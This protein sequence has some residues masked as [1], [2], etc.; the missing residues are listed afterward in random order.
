MDWEKAGQGWGARA[1]EW[2]YLA[3]PYAL[4][5]YE[6]VFDQLGV[7]TGIRLLDIACGSG[8]AAWMAA[9]RGA[10]VSGVDASAQLIRI[11][12]ARTPSGIFQTGD[13]FALPFPDQSFDV[14]TSFNGVWKGCEGALEE[15]R[16]VLIPEGRLASLSGATRTEWTPALLAQGPGVVSRQPCRSQHGRG[17]HAKCHRGHAEVHGIWRRGAGDGGRS[18][19]VARRGYRGARHGCRRTVCACDRGCRIRRVLPVP[20][21]SDRP[22]ACGWGRRADHIRVRLGD[23]SSFVARSALGLSN[24][25]GVEVGSASR[26]SRN[27]GSETGETRLLHPHILVA[28]MQ[29]GL[30]ANVQRRPTAISQL[31]SICASIVQTQSERFYSPRRPV[32]RISVVGLDKEVGTWG[33]NR[34]RGIAS[35]RIAV[36][37]TLQTALTAATAGRSHF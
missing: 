31:E 2:A 25:Q 19:R 33:K 18:Q 28:D 5:A 29:R 4:P 12:A 24:V 14:V 8:L 1:T 30:V 23:S 3:E 6:L 11:A 37:R 20:A 9:R 22:A 35:A 17:R 27:Q 7:D 21:R 15:A 34:H 36:Q 10:V 26:D 13:M 32:V 16:R